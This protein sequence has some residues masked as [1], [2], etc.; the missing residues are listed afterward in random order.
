VLL[1][2]PATSGLHDY[3]GD[4]NTAFP[5]Y[6]REARPHQPLQVFR[7]EDSD[8][9][10]TLTIC[11]TYPADYDGSYN[12][13]RLV[14]KPQ[15]TA[16]QTGNWFH[17]LSGLEDLDGVE[18]TLSVSAV[19]L[20]GNQS[21]E[22]ISL[23][24][25]VDNVAPVVTV[26][27]TVNQAEAGPNRTAT[28]VLSGTVSDGG[29]I[30]QMYAF[31]QTPGGE[32]RSQQIARDGGAWWFDLKPGAIGDYTIW[33]NAIDGAGNTTTMGP[34]Y[35]EIT[36]IAADL[37]TAIISAQTPA[38]ATSPISL[39]AR[40]SNNGGAEVAAGL[41]VA[42]YL[43]GAF[44]DTAATSGTLNAGESQD[45]TIVWD[46]DTP[47][48]YEL[49]V[50]GNDDGSGARPLALCSAPPETHQTVTILDVPLVE[51]W[52]LMSTYVNPF[53]TDASVVQLPIAGQYVV[54]QGFDGGAQSYYPDLPPAVNT[55]KDM[56]G[57]HGYWIKASAGI[58]PT[59][60]VVGEKLAEDQAIEL[61]AGWNLVSFLPCQSL[62]VAE[63]LQSI[64]GQYT[65]VLGYDQG[66]RSYYPDIDPSF[67]TLREMEP[68]FGYW[69]KMAQA[70]TLQY[71]I[72]GGGPL[73]GIGYSQS[74]TANTQY[75][76]GG[77][78]SQRDAYPHLGELLRLSTPSR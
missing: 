50:I 9:T 67:N 29:L 24:F 69:I 15:N 41:P 1:Y 52:N 8:G 54:I 55:L 12:R 23:T 3:K 49:T 75:P 38:G 35:V 73:S 61:D 76:P 28:A 7:G 37:S 47:G 44:I 30:V 58:S 6:D 42:F 57:E 74:A 17:T 25:R 66:A 4:D 65:A 63:A 72:T 48:D 68:L 60:R 26:S 78:G 43:D 59:L 27:S 56:D 22:T 31:V 5:Y 21:T 64:D 19:D 51:S 62:A 32:L 39:T 20:V 46:A 53:N 77:T 71:Q 33:I 10:W 45:F 34:F 36:C 18:Q 14:L 11:D 70:A 2:D 16:V 13:S 40:V